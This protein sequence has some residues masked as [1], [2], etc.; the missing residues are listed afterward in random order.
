[1]KFPKL[2]VTND[3]SIRV[4]GYIDT[5]SK[6]KNTY[7]PGKGY[8]DENGIVRIYSDH[9]PPL[10][11]LNSMPYIWEDKDDH[12]YRLS[13]PNKIILSM[14]KEEK[15][16]DDSKENIVKKT[17]PNEILYDER[18]MREMQ[19]RSDVFIPVIRGEDDFLKKIIK[20]VIIEKGINI[21]R[22]EASFDKI[23]QLANMKI[24]LQNNTAM[25]VKY[26][27]K[28]AELLGIDFELSVTDNGEDLKDPL[29]Q[30]LTYLSYKDDVLNEEELEEYLQ[31][32][33]KSSE[34]DSEEEK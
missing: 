16:V 19:S 22:L 34:S 25:S 29:N 20:M 5:E 23:Y 30:K 21:K 28:W 13:K 10:S 15:L 31:K 8:L 11:Q 17:L 3:K 12:K 26:F 1:M 32:F 18:E 27:V 2:I 6:P 9:E 24:A 7:I 14:F 33:E 4:L